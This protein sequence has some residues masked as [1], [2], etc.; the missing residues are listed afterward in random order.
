[1]CVGWEW[2]GEGREGSRTL[3]FPGPVTGRI[4]A[5]HT[6]I[7]RSG[8]EVCGEGLKQEGSRQGTAFERM[9]Q[10]EDAA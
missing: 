7:R 1:M 9:I 8:G 3:R 6:V 10:A 5:F 2:G 4:V